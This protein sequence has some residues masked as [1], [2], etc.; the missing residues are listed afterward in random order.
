VHRDDAGTF[1]AAGAEEWMVFFRDPDDNI[2][3]LVERRSI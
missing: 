3:A 1:G 2:V